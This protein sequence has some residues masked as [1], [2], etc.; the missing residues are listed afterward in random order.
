MLE[1]VGPL[2]ASVYWRRRALAAA[3]AVVVLLLA[4]MALPGGGDGDDRRATAGAAGSPTPEGGTPSSLAATP[5]AD[6]PGRQGDG[7]GIAG[8]TPVTTTTP[9][10]VPMTTR[11]PAP[12]PCPDSALTLRVQP[13]R[14]AYRV[15]ETPK[16]SLVV[17]NVSTVGCERDLGAAQQE[18]LLYRG[19]QRLWSSNDC[20]P[21]GEKVLRTLAPGASASFSVTWSGLGSRPR[22]AGERLRVGAGGYT[23][24]AR[25]GSLLS[26][27]TP[28]VL[29]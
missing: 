8:G 12:R 15:G 9:A 25:L 22:C 28:L 13:E 1:P 18:V 20:Y 29:R 5:P 2:P 4:W 19:M 23:L 26:K 27:R 6:D 16:L 17:R 3:V 24:L 10:A 7:D 14:P 11:P 21:Q